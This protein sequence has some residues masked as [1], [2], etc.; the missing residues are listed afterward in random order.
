MDFSHLGGEGGFKS[1][2]FD[3]TRTEKP[4]EQGNVSFQSSDVLLAMNE[5]KRGLAGGTCYKAPGGEGTATER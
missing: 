5:I 2:V 1:I 3:K 4:E